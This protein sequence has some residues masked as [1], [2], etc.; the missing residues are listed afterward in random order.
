MMRKFHHYHGEIAESCLQ[1]DFVPHR[2]LRN[3]HLMTIL[4]GFIPRRMGDFVKSGQ[5]RLF[6]I[7]SETSLLAHC[8]WQ[9]DK[10]KASMIILHGLEG[11]SESSHVIGIGSKIF[12]RGFN[13]IRLNMRNCGGSMQHAKSLY[14]AGMFEDVQALMRILH[15]EEGLKS[16]MLTGYSLGGNLILN[17]AS[18]HEESKSYKLLAV[19]AVSPSIDLA[20]AV[21]A[22]EHQEN[23]I[24][25]EWFLRTLKQKI[26]AKA[27]QHPHIYKIDGLDKVKTIRD[28]DDRFTA[29]YGGYGTA[30]RYYSEASSISKIKD[31]KCPVL[32][33]SAAD[34]PLVPV[35]SFYQ[36]K[37]NSPHVNLVITK[38]GG[39]GGFFQESN[40]EE[41]LF[42]RFWAENRVVTFATRIWQEVSK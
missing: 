16:F 3:R 14:N 24:Y 19:S 25:Q 37:E 7:N 26:L 15:E 29:P 41:P 1:L 18:R 42:D 12:A 36:L 28:F 33:I 4:P 2:L 13:V 8:H 40:E 35:D 27:E 20:H 32:I 9:A 39:H 17:T 6:K 34:D 23:R 38:H 5:A 31:I 11:S 22:I 10:H 30:E 21:R